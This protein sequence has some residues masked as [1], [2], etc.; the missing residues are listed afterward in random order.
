[1]LL[2]IAMTVVKASSNAQVEMMC[3]ICSA[4]D[5]LIKIS[6]DEEGLKLFR[7]LL[8]E[9]TTVYARKG[10]DLPEDAGRWA[11]LYLKHLGGYARVVYLGDQRGSRRSLACPE[12]MLH[13]SEL[14]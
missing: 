10:R 8:F 12:R 3:E 11:D 6:S 2:M 13:P 4:L 1:M 9:I 7:H 14:R 5:T